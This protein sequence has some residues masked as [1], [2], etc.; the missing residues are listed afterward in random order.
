MDLG[1]CSPNSCCQ[2]M[3]RRKR[4]TTTKNPNQWG[5]NPGMQEAGREVGADQMVVQLVPAWMA[6]RRKI[7]MSKTSMQTMQIPQERHVQGRGN[8]YRFKGRSF[9]QIVI[10]LLTEKPVALWTQQPS[11]RPADAA[12][13]K[14]NRP[15]GFAIDCFGT[16]PTNG[17]LFHS[18]VYFMLKLISQWEP[19]PLKWQV[20]GIVWILCAERPKY[21]PISPAFLLSSPVPKMFL[22]LSTPWREKCI[23][24][25]CRWGSDRGPASYGS[26]SG[27]QRTRAWVHRQ[28]NMLLYMA[29]L[30]L[31][32]D[33]TFEQT[34]PWLS[35]M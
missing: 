28:L 15:R 13:S 3:E 29:Q 22:F 14:K 7:S 10:I 18:P 35:K 23:C 4:T 6:S 17:N 24:C 16:R 30:L 20:E 33:F 21:S 32:L 19:H 11:A 12:I 25:T 5:R 2:R 1:A 8:A 31:E 34:F 26:G 27:E 9:L